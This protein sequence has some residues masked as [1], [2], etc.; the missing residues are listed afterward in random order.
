MPWVW[1]HEAVLHQQ[2]WRQA[3]RAHSQGRREVAEGG[4]AGKGKGGKAGK[5][6]W[7]SKGGKAG[8]GK[9]KGLCIGVMRHGSCSKKGCRYEY[10]DQETYN[11]RKTCEEYAKNG[12]CPGKYSCGM[13][14]PEDP[15]VMSNE[16]MRKCTHNGN[17]ESANAAEEMS[18]D[19][20]GTQSE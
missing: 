5:G 8:K 3:H 19:T 13:R 14:H 11:N 20:E 10:V 1:S 4:K 18:T 15:E 16:M 2:G 12:W 7:N 9:G 17:G 6:A